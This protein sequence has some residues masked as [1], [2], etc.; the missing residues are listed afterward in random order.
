MRSAGAIEE[1]EIELTSEP[2]PTCA[3]IP[4]ATVVGTESALVAMEGDAAK[5][6]RLAV[7]VE[8]S[9]MFAYR[10]RACT[11]QLA[12]NDAER[13]VVVDALAVPLSS[14]GG[15]L[16]GDGP[17]KVIH[18]VAFDARLLAEQGVDL[19]NVHDTAIAAQMLGRSA[20]GLASLLQ[21]ELGVSVDK[22]MQHHDWR[23]RPLDEAMLRYLSEDVAHL[24]ALESAL[25][26]QLAQ[27]GIED[28]VIEE[29]RY[30]LS[31]A[32]QAIQTPNQAPAYIR[33]KGMEQL[34]AA[35]LAAL[36]ALA[37]LREIEAQHID[38]PPQH[39]LSNAT[40]MLLARSRLRDP[41]AIARLPAVAAS[42]LGSGFVNRLAEA[43]TGAGL[44]VPDADRVWLDRPRIPL[45]IAQARRRREAR[46]GQWRKTEA[47]RRCV[48]EQVVLPGHCLKDLAQTAVETIED[49]AR[50]KGIGEFRVIRDG[51][52][53]LQALHATDDAV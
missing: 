13:I 21:S 16:G 28:A 43:M 25:W 51:E 34:P 19:D 49:L 30:R 50:I 33:I 3:A 46:V 6:T 11:V 48:C 14:L 53:M 40:L 47:A 22:G 38:I 5:A 32:R 37:D 44:D 1:A 2:I 24:E 15:L 12:W 35:D 52:A 9:G 10:A 31:C 26:G 4:T 20:T 36:R 8:A 29:T 45:E 18:D 41:H 23:L 42:S 39:L 17:V 7:D 27:H